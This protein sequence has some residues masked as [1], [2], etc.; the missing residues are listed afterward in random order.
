MAKLFLHTDLLQACY[1]RSVC[2]YWGNVTFKRGVPGDLLFTPVLPF[3]LYSTVCIV[4]WSLVI[5]IL[6]DSC[7]V[8]FT[9]WTD[10]YVSC[11]DWSYS[12]DSETSVYERWPCMYITFTFTERKGCCI[13]QSIHRFPP[14]DSSTASRCC[15]FQLHPRQLFTL[16]RKQRKQNS[17]KN[18][19]RHHKWRSCWSKYILHMKTKDGCSTKENGW[20]I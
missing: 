15:K 5:P 17:G 3:H 7:S 14:E 13:I 19:A 11:S 2:I 16:E 18:D 10:F 20:K 12:V 6:T 1:K 8:F 4:V 9:T